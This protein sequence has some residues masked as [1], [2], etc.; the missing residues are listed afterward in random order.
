MTEEQTI[1]IKQ[2]RTDAKLRYAAL[3]LD[4]LKSNDTAGG[5][6]FE[7]AH[8]ESFLFHLVGVKEAFLFELNLYYRLRVSDSQ[9]SLGNMHKA[10]NEAELESPELAEIYNLEND[11]ESWLY[12]AKSIRDHSMHIS[13]V[14]RHFHLGGESHR[15]V[16]LSNPKTGK[17]IE[18]HINEEFEHWLTSMN[19][20]ISRLR[21]S[22][23]RFH[24]THWL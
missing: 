5:N 11:N 9:I 15:K 6:D 20:L 14:A 21:V 22:G 4:E 18:R 3:H 2:E 1:N 23:T 8:Q 19:E 16:F 12:H 17:V 7:R 24:S 10:L 13:N